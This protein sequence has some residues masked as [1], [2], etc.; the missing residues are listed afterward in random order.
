M[1]DWH[2]ADARPA[3]PVP[4][5]IVVD[6]GV[7]RLQLLGALDAPGGLARLARDLAGLGG[8]VPVMAAA[9]RDLVVVLEARRLPSAEACFLGWI[10]AAAVRDIVIDRDV[11]W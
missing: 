10:E 2:E 7:V 9:G 8:G 3:W 5:G 11:A 4:A 6:R 1:S